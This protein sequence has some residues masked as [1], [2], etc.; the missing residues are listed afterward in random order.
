MSKV[1]KTRLQCFYSQLLRDAEIYVQTVHN[2]RLD[3]TVMRV[4]VLAHVPKT[5]I[6]ETTSNVLEV[7]VTIIEIIMLS[8]WLQYV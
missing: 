1:S 5:L 8:L 7:R 3:Y 2:V 6:V 4:L